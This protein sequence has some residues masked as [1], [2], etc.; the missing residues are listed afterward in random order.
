MWKIEA[1][2]FWKRWSHKILDKVCAPFRKTKTPV[3]FGCNHMRQ[4]TGFLNLSKYGVK[5][6]GQQNIGIDL[7]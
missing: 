3:P 7:C 1:P 2:F 4:P 5:F 6:S